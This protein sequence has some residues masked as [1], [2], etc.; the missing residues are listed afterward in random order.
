[1]L[2][3]TKMK[4]GSKTK[5]EL[6]NEIL[7]LRRQVATLEAQAKKSR[8]PGDHAMRRGEQIYRSIMESI[9][10]AYFEIDH[11]GNFNSFSDSTCEILGST[12][13]ELSGT[14][15]Q[16][17]VSGET[18]GKM[19]NF[20]NGISQTG[21]PAKISDLEIVRK[22]QSRRVLDISASLNQNAAGEI[23]G[24]RG[25]GRDVTERKQVEKALWESEERY[26]NLFE[27]SRD[28]LFITTREGIHIDVNQSYVDL[29]GYT[30]EELL[31]LK[32]EKIY[33]NPQD[34]S[35]F[36]REMELKGSVRD[37]DVR[38]CKKDGTEM[39][40]LLT[41]TIRK[42]KDGSIAG[43]QGII[44]D[45]TDQKALLERWRRYDFIVNTSKQFMTL[46]N[47][48][49]QYEAVN[50]AYCAAQHK[51]R[52]EILGHTAAEVWGEESFDAVVKDDLDSCFSG[53]E[54]HHQQWFRFGD[55]ESRCYNV[56]YYP[57]YGDSTGVTHA[58]VTHAV[59][60]THDITE[61]KHAE[62]ALRESEEKYRLLIENASDAIFIIQDEVVKFPNPRTEE[63]LGYSAEELLKTPF[64]H[65]IHPVDRDMV[66]SRHEN[67]LRNQAPPGTC[68]FRIVNRN[69]EVLWV[70]LNDVVITWGGQLAALNLLRDITPQKKLEA[71]LQQAQKMEALGTLAGGIAH[72]FNNL[73]MGIMGNTSLMLYET[74]HGSPNYERLQNIERLVD[75]G[76]KLTR[77]LLG[78]ARG[79]RYEVRPLSLNQV[80]RETSDTFATAKK[81]IRVHQELAENLWGIKA[82]QGQIEQALLNLY[83]N[84]ADAMPSGGDLFVR[85]TN[86]AHSEIKGRDFKPRSGNYVMAQ[87][88]DT[89][90]GMDKQTSDRIFDPFF[91]TKGLSKGTG[92]GLS[93][94]YGTVKAHGGYIDVNSQRGKGT[95]FT[96]YLPASE[97]EPQKE[98][99][100][101]E[102]A[103]R[104]AETILLVD[105]EDMIITVG[106]EMLEIMG[107]Q[108]VLAKGGKEAIEVYDAG[109]E[110]IDMVI[111]DMIM[112]DMGAK[113]T[114]AALKRINPDVKV[115][116][117]SG[118]S[119]DGQASEILEQGCDACVRQS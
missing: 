71:Q 61:A 76:S 13:H 93:S 48:E 53:K 25:V 69:G 27:H 63:M 115:L 32:A 55:K 108:T 2:Q 5:K 10:E 83:V 28:A 112:P 109:G 81:E 21:K 79:G 4:D 15:I 18:L 62:E 54:I 100:T 73:L 39:D 47:K 57:Y 52:E 80:I 8:P 17:Y 65:F 85:T 72:N 16:S 92:L 56:S 30:R 36:Q 110:D 68:S 1:M 64:A 3:G 103:L 31:N 38:F 94:V 51:T 67:R 43:Y 106:S 75:S 41:A 86:V 90:V 113:E 89:G 102:E 98:I 33:A 44:R 91:T 19:H 119:I 20:F 45:I 87:I 99:K 6:I 26:R 82:D 46:I 107:Y 42:A 111:L 78:Y 116:L 84:A 77:Q 23:I 58:V 88:A 34:R 59:V 24:Y 66:R 29:F 50:E 11:N 114:Y 96:I 101:S 12:R 105:D 118:Y 104:G 117:S 37:F 35:R 40:C 22:D 60:I 95:A 14:N 97:I 70:Q 49:Y 7:Q 74:N 9:G